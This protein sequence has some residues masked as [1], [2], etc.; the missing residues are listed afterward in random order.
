MA[1]QSQRITTAVT[2]SEI[3]KAAR[4]RNLWLGATDPGIRLFKGQIVENDS[5]GAGRSDAEGRAPFEEIS[6]PRVVRK[7]LQLEDPHAQRVRLAFIGQER[8]GHSASLRVTVNGHQILRPPSPLAAPDAR[9]Y[10]A[11]AKD[12]GAWN[13]SRWYYVDIPPACLI[14]GDNEITVQAKGGHLGWNIMV[15]DYRD[16]EKGMPGP[17]VLPKTSRIS[18]DGGQTWSSER[19]EYVMR[20][21]LDRY[22]KSGNLMSPVVDAAGEQDLAVK[23]RRS[24]LA[25]NLKADAETPSGTRIR[26]LA[27]TGSRPAYDDAHW[28]DWKPCPIDNPAGRYVQWKAEFSTDDPSQTPVLKGITLEADVGETPAVTPLRVVHAQNAEILRSSYDFPHEDYNCDLLR[29]LR[30]RFELDAVVVGAQTEF[31]KIMRL[32]R[33]AYDIPL[34]NCT[35]FPWNVL[36]WLVLERDEQG[37]IVKNTYKQRRRDAMCLYPNVVL[38][39]A[40]QSMGIPARHVNFHS[41]GMTG[42]EIAEVWSNDYRKWVHLDATRDYYWYDPDTCVPLSTLEIHRALADRLE[43]IERWDRPYLFRQDLNAL[44]KDLPIALREG[45]H[46][47]SVREGALHLFHTFCHFRIV[48]R[49]NVFSQAAPLPVSQGTEVWAWDGYLNWADDK[50]PPL[51]H[52]SN[53]TN[54]QADFYPTLNQTRLTVERTDVPTELQVYL[55]TETPCFDGYQAKIDQGL[56][57][58][59]QSTFRWSLHKGMNILQIRSCNT[60]D[61]KGIISALAVEV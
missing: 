40:C 42:H 53:H 8:K 32:S 20:L 50:V 46:Q 24:L 55:E 27:R 47:Y 7:R 21:S 56:W 33:W 59:Q 38:V 19:G 14:K 13:W 11:L 10:W 34:K 39:A 41:E 49:Y 52:F 44:E 26:F 28:S 45:D 60:A 5:P 31:E 17:V 3:Y 35:H 2:A 15:A 1:D 16:Y 43:E 48:P 12:E 57:H 9:Q 4:I 18:R 22:R 36:D 25:L 58:D 54:R 51:L 37:H 61:V 29:E 6:G 30:Q 23:N